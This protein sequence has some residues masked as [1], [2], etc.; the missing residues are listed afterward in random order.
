LLAQDGVYARL[1]HTQFGDETA[2]HT[3]NEA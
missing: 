1:Y 2:V 3:L